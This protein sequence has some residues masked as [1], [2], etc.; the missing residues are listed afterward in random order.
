MK[1]I[2]EVRKDLRELKKHAH[3][4]EKLQRVY[5]T[6]EARIKMLKRLGENDKVK[7]LIEK[8]ESYI[9][10]IKL[11]EEIDN[12]RLLEEKYMGAIVKLDPIDKSIILD[13][14]INGTPYWKVGYELGF[15]EEGVRKRINKILKAIALNV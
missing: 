7:A 11:C 3:A 1:G 14:C 8:E 13:A 6:H 2:N 10:S 9:S 12:A 15:S 4:I 5:Q